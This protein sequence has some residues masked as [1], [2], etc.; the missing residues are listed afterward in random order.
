MRR[1]R[2]TLELIIKMNLHFDRRREA[3]GSGW[4]G[5]GVGVH[6]PKSCS[7]LEERAANACILQTLTQQ[8][9]GDWGKEYGRKKHPVRIFTHRRGLHF[10][11]RMRMGRSQIIAK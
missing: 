10:A 1:A 11:Q 4:G 7:R 2:P 8:R 3:V 6:Y 5:S 9:V